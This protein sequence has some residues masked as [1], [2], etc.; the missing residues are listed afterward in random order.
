MYRDHIYLN[1]HKD[2]QGGIF[3]LYTTVS[4]RIWTRNTDAP[5]LDKTKVNER[6][7]TEGLHYYQNV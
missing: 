2:C 7:K 6:R 5:D 1:G 4:M 3:T